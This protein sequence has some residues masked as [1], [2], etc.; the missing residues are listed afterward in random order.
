MLSAMPTDPPPPSPTFGRRRALALLAGGAGALALGA[1]GR[2]GDPSP[3]SGPTSTTGGGSSTS[4]ASSG[5][6]GSSGAGVTAEVPDETGGPYPADGTN[7]PDVLT[8]SGVVRRDITSSFGSRS[9]SVSGVPLTLALSIVH[10]GTG[11]PYPGAAMYLWHADPLGRYSLYSPGVTDQSWLRGVQAGDANG[12]LTFQSVFPG[13]Y[14]GRWP[15]LH[16]EVFES[17]AGAT[18]GQGKVKTSQMAMPAE[19]CNLVYTTTGYETSASNL[20]RTSL[21]RDMV[22]ADGYALQVPTITGDV[23]GLTATLTIAV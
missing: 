14:D 7:G 16:F 8:E 2:D 5:S 21:A 19:T 6:G 3:A 22:F 20:S 4:A 12:R 1:C 18:S 10:A 9:G 11:R 15:H 13:A 17:L 23:Q